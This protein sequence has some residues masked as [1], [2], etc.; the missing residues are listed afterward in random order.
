[1][2]Y[3]LAEPGRIHRRGRRAFRRDRMPKRRHV[4]VELGGG[5]KVMAEYW[6]I[7]SR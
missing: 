4:M 3:V 1:M 2:E 7:Q 5:K 6:D